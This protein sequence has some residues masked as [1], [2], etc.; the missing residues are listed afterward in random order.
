MRAL[1]QLLV[2]YWPRMLLATLLGTAVVASNMGLLAAAAYLIAAASVTHLMALLIL[3]LYAVRLLSAARGAARYAERLVSHRVT[4]DVL[5]QLRVRQYDRIRLLGPAGMARERSGDALGRVLADVEELQDAYLLFVSPVAV[6]S[7]VAILLVGVLVAFSSAIA[8]AVLCSVLACGVA[9]PLVIA[10]LTRVA[11]RDLVTVRAEL[12]AHLVDG[13]QGVRDIVS[14]GADSRYQGRTSSYTRRMANAEAR[15]ADV[16]SGREATVELLTTLSMLTALALS[17]SLATRHTISALYVAV[18]ALLTL[19]AFEA[20]RPLGVAAETASGVRAAAR[21]VLAIG[22]RTDSVADPAVPI[23]LEA[24][25]SIAFEAVTMVYP[26][27]ERPAV[28]QVCFEVP[29]GSRVAVVG[30]SGAGK[31]TLVGLLT[32]AWDPTYGRV[33]VG[34]TDIRTCSLHD[35]RS[36]VGIVAQDSYI[37]NDT[38]RRNL[39]LARP[40]A[41]TAELEE[42]LDAVGLLDLVRGLP[43][44]LDTWTGEH[45]ERLSGGERQRVAVARVLLQNAPIILLDEVTANLDPLTESRVLDTLYRVTEGR[46]VLTITHRLVGLDRVDRIVV[47]DR[48]QAV[49]SGTHDSLYRAGGLYRKMLD[50]QE[51]VLAM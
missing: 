31:T 45:G 9:V 2:P 19:A 3:P 20:I 26:G 46:T 40:D 36:T 47:L 7:A 1:L 28:Q 49:E 4:F 12:N 10:A 43:Q 34:K 15:L 37:F 42:T 33:V 21:R 6:A 39:L 30:P 18:P 32:R 25:Y 41:S 48:G 38:V 27:S 16:S 24:P 23:A 17:V 44:G 14:N 8:W 29:N 5:A 51:N 22:E 35:L 50:T 11:G 13:V